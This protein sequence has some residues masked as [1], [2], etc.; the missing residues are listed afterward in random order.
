M[1]KGYLITEY[2]HELEINEV[3][4]S[5]N[6]YVTGI[7]SS[8]GRRNNNGRVYEEGTMKREV[9]KVM[10]KITKKCLWGELG[11]PP[12]VFGDTEILT[13][14][15]WKEIQNISD[16]EV[17]ATLNPDTK[18]IEYH[19][20]EK[21]VAPFKGD[22]IRFNGRQ[23]DMA[24]TPNHRHLLYSR[25]NKPYFITSDE[26]VNSDTL[27]VRKSYI[28][29]TGTWVSDVEDDFFV[30][31]GVEKTYSANKDQEKDITIDLMTL[32]RFMGIW[33][34]EG[35][36]SKNN[37]NRIEIYQNEGAKADL[38]REILSAFPEEL[39]WKETISD[40]K[41]LFSL[42]DGRLA[43]I[44]K[45]L[46]NCYDK[47]IPDYFKSLP[48]EYLQELIY[49]FGLGDG[50]G[51]L[52]EGKKDIFSTSERLIDDFHEIAFKSGYSCRK[53]KKICDVDYVFAGRTI[54]A[55]NKSPLYFLKI[56]TTNGIYIDDRFMSFSKEAYEGNVYCVRVKNQNF[57]VRN[58]DSVSFFTGN[59]PEINPDKIAIR[60]ESLEWQ[61]NDLYGKA[62]ILDTPQGQIAKTL[63]KE[64]LIG[65]SS[66][67]LGTVHEDGTVNE[68]YNL[69][70][71][72]L[73]T[74]PSNGPSW[75]NGVLEGKTW[76][77]ASSSDFVD[78]LSEDKAREEYYKYVMSIINEI[79]KKL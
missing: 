49:W 16:I 76:D 15:G 31:K 29:K 55:K 6:L 25:H 10:D 34:A 48:I 60:V 61:G 30:L 42:S 24:F 37:R 54:E 77:L 21:I 26:I 74:D 66:R 64:G 18:E 51:F 63:V 78:I 62:K 11:H 59:C 32:V 2:S 46:G 50:R 69:I 65:I 23:I 56:L 27:K 43:Q 4:N 75:L 57:Y 36:V 22:M 39:K 72:D 17:I 71:W 45:P 35:Y 9:N 12:C 19:E 3:G 1:R 7:F 41:V 38:I 79:K 14:E 70:T 68:D 13:Q 53:T 40:N 52:D 28:P 58:K 73:V 47:Y 5:K 20:A 44:L 67:G 33:L 8:H